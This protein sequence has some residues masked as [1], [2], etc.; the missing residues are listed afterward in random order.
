VETSNVWIANIISAFVVI[1]AQLSVFPALWESGF[2]FFYFRFHAVDV[3]FAVIERFAF[4]KSTEPDFSALANV[5][6]V[7]CVGF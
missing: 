2:A 6:L 7:A 1:I 5:F 3:A 4:T